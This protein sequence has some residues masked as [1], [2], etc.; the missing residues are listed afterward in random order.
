MDARHY[1]PKVLVKARQDARKTQQ[2]VAEDLK[3]DR[4]TIYRAEAGTNVSYEL[5]AGMCKVYGLP[6]TDV[7]LPYPEL[8]SAV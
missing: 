3:V 1:D 5:L 2:D 4:Q 7:I 8:A 6:M